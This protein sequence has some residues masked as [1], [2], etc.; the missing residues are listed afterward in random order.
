MASKSL[1]RA[2]VCIAIAA[3]AR[4]CCLSALLWSLPGSA[5]LYA[6]QS[7]S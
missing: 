1:L 5:H 3:V 6:K 4:A 2:A 7:L